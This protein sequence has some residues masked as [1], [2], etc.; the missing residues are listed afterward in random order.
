MRRMRRRMSILKMRR[1]LMTTST[2]T[3]AWLF[4]E[5]IVSGGKAILQ[6]L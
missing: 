1:I 2:V 6:F 5:L 3:T 4:F